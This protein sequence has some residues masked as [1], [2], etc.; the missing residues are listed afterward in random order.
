MA[1]TA[2][3]MQAVEEQLASGSLQLPVYSA[4]A[5]RMQTEAARDD[6]DAQRV[7]QVLGQDPALAAQVLRV[8]NSPFY[9]GLSKIGTLTAAAQRLGLRQVVNIAVLTAQRAAHTSSDPLLKSLMHRLWQHSVA[10]AVGAKWL[11]ERTNC[12]EQAAEAFLAGLL[13]DVGALLLLRVIESLRGNGP[14]RQAMSEALVLEII[15]AFHA[16]QGARLIRHWGL[17]DSFAQIAASHH[18]MEIDAG[19][20]L[21]QLV[22][23]SNQACH[24]LGIGVVN[25]P[26][27]RLST[28]H[29]SEL[30]GVREV[31]LAEL[32][33]AIEDG[34]AQLA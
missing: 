13:H 24:K 27:I 29:E 7:A 28:L 18:A 25:D 34:V 21:A 17:P 11:A 10:C 8:A 32:E 22:R 15:G 31:V 30:L 23:L 3:L 9:G 6:A 14:G 16:E 1:D 4:T 20:T 12:R 26:A 33:V 19:D 5:S 2:T